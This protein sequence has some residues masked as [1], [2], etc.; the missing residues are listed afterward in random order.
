MSPLFQVETPK[1]RDSI[2]LGWISRGGNDTS[3]TS[4]QQLG[5]TQCSSQISRAWARPRGEGSFGDC[6]THFGI[7]ALPSLNSPVTLV[8][9]S[10]HNSESLLIYGGGG[11][12]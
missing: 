1:G 8:S 3:P 2:P 10:L 9:K 7:L 6:W 12:K 4:E 11:G 5:C